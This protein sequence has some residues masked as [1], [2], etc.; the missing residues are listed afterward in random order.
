MIT[1]KEIQEQKG[2][3]DEK[4]ADLI[5]RQKH[6]YIIARDNNRLTKEELNNIY[7]ILGEIYGKRKCK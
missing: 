2:Y 1:I 6:E 5:N 7:C 4:I 3:S